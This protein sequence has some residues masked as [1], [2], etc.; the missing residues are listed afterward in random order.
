VRHSFLYPTV[1]LCHAS[2]FH[3]AQ[4]AR[5]VP[6]F[7][8]VSAITTNS[9]AQGH[10]SFHSAAQLAAGNR[11]GCQEKKAG[12][13]CPPYIASPRVARNMGGSARGTRRWEAGLN[14]A[15]GT[16]NRGEVG[17]QKC[18][19]AG[20]KQAGA[21]SHKEQRQFFGLFGEGRTTRF[22]HGR[23]PKGHTQ[24]GASLAARRLPVGG[25]IVD[26]ACLQR[27][28]RRAHAPRQNEPSRVGRGA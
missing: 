12:W 6:H 4:P 26:P 5:C 1:F 16:L 9:T 14:L 28:E 23:E 7:P 11:V 3:N 19:G 21:S 20:V 15:S 22:E 25:V 10:C 13:S 27:E 24:L 2:C 18:K 17:G 8:A